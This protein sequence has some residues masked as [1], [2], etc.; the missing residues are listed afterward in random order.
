MRAELVSGDF[1]SVGARYEGLGLTA[2]N[3]LPLLRAPSAHVQNSREKKEVM[4]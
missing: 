1:K 2:P 3:F 4:A